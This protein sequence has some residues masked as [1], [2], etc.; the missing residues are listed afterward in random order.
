MIGVLHDVTELTEAMIAAKEA[1]AA[2]SNFIA[3]ISHELRTPLNAILGFSEL[4]KM[5]A[6]GRLGDSRYETYAEDIHRS[7]QHLLSVINDILSISRLEVGNMEIQEEDAIDVQKLLKDC[8]NW[9][10]GQADEAGIE[11]RLD[12]AADVPP[13]RADPRL[14]TQILLNLLSNAVKFTAKNGLIDIS[15]VTN[16]AGGVVITVRDTGIGM[17]DE[18]V[19]RIGERF[20]QFDSGLQRKYAGTGIGLSIVKRLVELHGGALVIE[21]TLNVGT[22]MSVVM[23]PERSAAPTSAKTRAA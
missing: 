5:K 1:S 2:K 15:A 22:T 23:P 11:L 18:Q 8:A 7:G 17:T 12:A 9:V 16:D 3:N 19:A 6:L 4:M 13:L 21:S 14:L 10:H 20:L